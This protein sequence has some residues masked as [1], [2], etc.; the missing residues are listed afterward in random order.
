MLAEQV[1]R[2]RQDVG[3]IADGGGAAARE[4]HTG[5]GK[6]LP[7]ERVRLLLDEGAPFLELSQLAAWGMY[8]DAVPAAGLITGI[9]RVSGR[10]C[11]IVAND[12]TD[13]PPLTGPVSMLVHGRL[14]RQ[15]G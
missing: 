4:R 7:R 11:V 9:G 3:Q 13:L 8:G 1:D 12:A 10:D 15:A 14:C 2:L 5:R 6:L